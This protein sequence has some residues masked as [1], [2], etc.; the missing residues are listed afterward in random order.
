M[1]D[2]I[3][4]ISCYACLDVVCSGFKPQCL[5]HMSNTL[6]LAH[7]H[8]AQEDRPLSASYYEGW[9]F[10]KYLKQTSSLMREK[11]AY[12]GRMPSHS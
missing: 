1:E 6:F 3:K 5:K 10:W 2:L 9:S 8:P 7:F 12:C 4:I 11:L